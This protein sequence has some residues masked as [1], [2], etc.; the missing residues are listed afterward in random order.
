MY[1]GKGTLLWRYDYVDVETLQE[2][3]RVNEQ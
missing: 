3:A 2:W 1:G